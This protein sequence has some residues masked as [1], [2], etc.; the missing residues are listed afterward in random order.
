VTSTE[1]DAPVCVVFGNPSE[2][3]LPMERP[4]AQHEVRSAAVCGQCCNLVVLNEI[5]LGWCSVGHH[6]GKLG[7]CA[8]HSSAYTDARSTFGVLQAVRDGHQAHGEC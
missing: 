4:T 8:R 7:Y 1:H 6:A 2:R 3:V 5:R